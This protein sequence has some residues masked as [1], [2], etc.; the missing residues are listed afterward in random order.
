MKLILNAN[1]NSILPGKGIL[2]SSTIEVD[3]P[4]VQIILELM[5]KTFPA[6]EWNFSIDK[7]VPVKEDNVYCQGS[8]P[9]G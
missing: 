5:K 9:L 8:H 4:E 2:F 1:K 7:I 6:G 3:S